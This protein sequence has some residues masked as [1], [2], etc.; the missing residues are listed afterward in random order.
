[1]TLRVFC[2]RRI[3]VRAFVKVQIILYAIFLCAFLSFS[4]STQEPHPNP[5]SAIAEL[6]T[7]AESGD[8]FARHDLSNFLSQR[9]SSTP[10]YDIALEWLC[11]S[12]DRGQPDAQFLLGYLYEQGRG[13]P[14]NYAKAAENYHA[15]TLQG[16]A[17]A[18]NN[19]AALYQHGRGVPK[20]LGKALQLYLAS[21]RQGNPVAQCNLASL[22]LTG[23][24]V[25]RD[26]DVT[27]RWFRAAAEQR[28][29]AAQHNLAVIYFKGL[30]VPVDYAQALAWERLAAEQG[31]PEAETGLGYF[32]ETG[33]G[34]SL[35]YVA[36]FTWYSRASAHGDPLAS[37]LG[38]SLSR[39]MTHRQ[40]D[41]ARRHCRMDSRVSGAVAEDEK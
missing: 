3:I 35:D 31:Y 39:R 2:Y 33:K 16:H 30:G 10:G 34:L 24:A 28:Y 21:A 15:A 13:L 25:P 19:L 36:A 12:A 32:Y 9:D 6:K 14:R 11:Q 37:A 5:V 29:P 8:A 4:A 22:Y 1:M 27:V 23:A 18:Q 20:N 41:E 38:K 26:L 40:L 17:I 7:R